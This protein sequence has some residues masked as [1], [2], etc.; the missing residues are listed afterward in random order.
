MNLT[1][2][3]LSNR[4]NVP[5]DTIRYYERIG[6]LTNVPRSANGNRYYDDRLQDRIEMILCL[7][8]A[9]IS[10]KSLKRYIE[11]FQNGSDTLEQREQLLKDQRQTLLKKQR[12]INESLREINKTIRLY[13][14]GFIRENEADLSDR[15]KRKLLMNTIDAI[16]QRKSIRKFN[17]RPVSDDDLK[18]IIDVAK[19]APSWINAQSVRVTVV[20]GARLEE[21]RK[22][23][24]ELNNDE[25]VHTSSVISYDGMDKWD[26][27]SQKN[28]MGWVANAQ[29][30]LGESWMKTAGQQSNRLFDAQAIVYLSLPVN[31]SEWSLID[32]GL[33]AQSIMLAAFDLGIDSIPAFEFIKY[34]AQL[35]KHLE[36]PEGEL[37]IFAVGLGYRDAEFELNQLSAD[38]MKSEDTFRLL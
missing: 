9:G 20:R 21:I 36:L 4:L 29:K 30:Q 10:I 35:A 8:N 26:E 37:P 5:M 2:T 12:D 27:R 23:H 19:H 24:A 28:M 14:S 33:L 3:Q 16:L 17:D 11:L 25:N 18:R 38:R 34:P 15:K 32:M 31:Y 1:I 6:I 13:Q 7:R 22:Q